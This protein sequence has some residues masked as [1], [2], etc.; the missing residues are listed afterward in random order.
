VK[1]VIWKA[2]AAWL[3]PRP[4]G[5]FRLD[6]TGNNVGYGEF[7]VVEPPHRVAFTWGW[8]GSD[9]QPPGSSEVEITLTADGNDTVVRLVHR[10][11]APGH[12]EFN[13]MGW[14]HYLPRLQVAVAAG[15]PGPDPWASQ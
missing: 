15:D 2:K 8:E 4:G 3:E 11:L 6:V 9:E 13:E 5:Q 7:T 10:G 12:V 14:D 1:M